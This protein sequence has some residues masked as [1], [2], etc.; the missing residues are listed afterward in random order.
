MSLLISGD[1]NQLEVNRYWAIS[2]FVVSRLQEK[3]LKK[4][5]LRKEVFLWLTVPRHTQFIMARKS[6]QQTVCVTELVT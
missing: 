6:C 1:R 2:A 4:N 5:N 3:H